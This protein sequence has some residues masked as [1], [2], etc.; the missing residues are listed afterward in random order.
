VLV[1]VEAIVPAASRA[2][3]VEEWRAN[4]LYSGEAGVS[5]G[6]ILI[7]ALRVAFALRASLLV[8]LAAR[9]SRSP[10]G[11]VVGLVLDG[12]VVGALLTVTGVPSG[13]LLAA[14]AATVSVYGGLLFA[15]GR[16][17]RPAT[18]GPA[19]R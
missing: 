12:L 8:A 4:M 13:L 14:T 3:F 15:F 16:T 2:R 7:A 9:A 11:R 5:Q 17:R 10:A 1:L 19:P 6:T 18:A